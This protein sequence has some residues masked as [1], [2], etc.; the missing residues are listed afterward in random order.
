[1]KHWPLLMLVV[2]CNQWG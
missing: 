1:M 2:T